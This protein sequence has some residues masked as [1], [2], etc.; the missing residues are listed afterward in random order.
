M[1]ILKCRISNSIFYMLSYQLHLFHLLFPIGQ[2]RLTA[3]FRKCRYIKS[4]LCNLEHLKENTL[5]KICLYDL[6]KYR[7]QLE[8]ILLH[9][10]T[11][12]SCINVG[13]FAD[14]CCKTGAMVQSLLSLFNIQTIMPCW[15]TFFFS[16]L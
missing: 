15:L 10:S 2:I 16:T 11:T 13:V 5:Y 9:K 3:H 6:Y 4:N 12:I 1:C 8:N 7:C 14:V